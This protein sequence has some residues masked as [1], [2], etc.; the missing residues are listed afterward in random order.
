[1]RRVGG[2]KIH[3][4]LAILVGSRPKRHAQVIADSPVNLFDNH[5]SNCYPTR[6]WVGIARR[7]SAFLKTSFSLGKGRGCR[8]AA[9]GDQ[10]FQS[11][12]GSQ[13]TRFEST[14]PMHKSKRL[15]ILALAVIAG[16]ASLF[17]A[18]A[19]SGDTIVPLC[20]K[21]RNIGVPFYL[22]PRYIAAGA[23]DGP[24]PTSPP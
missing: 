19:V 1:M 12:A 17:Q 23:T 18:I 9:P 8:T 5:L 10:K 20:F 4:S 24:C 22:R 14:N 15:L 7:D 2:R 16:T 13:G 3:A 6:H 11:V 21:N